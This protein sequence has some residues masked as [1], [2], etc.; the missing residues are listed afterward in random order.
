MPN[1]DLTPGLARLSE[2]DRTDAF[3]FERLRRQRKWSE[4]S[5]PRQ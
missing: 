2:P 4:P 3:P 5:S 1:V